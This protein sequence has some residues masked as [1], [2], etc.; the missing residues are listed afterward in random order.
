[1]LKLLK[2]IEFLT[3][4]IDSLHYNLKKQ[5]QQQN[6]I[7]FIYILHTFTHIPPTNET[8]ACSFMYEKRRA[9]T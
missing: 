9:E 7:M 3:Q 8:L 4:S 6:P 2:T 1:M 5:Q